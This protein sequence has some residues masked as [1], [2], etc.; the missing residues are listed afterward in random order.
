[1]RKLGLITAALLASTSVAGAWPWSGSVTV[2]A[3]DRDRQVNDYDRRTDEG[4]R[5]RYHA[6][7]G[8]YDDNRFVQIAAL[9][10][11]AKSRVDVG[12]QA[13]AFSRLRVQAVDGRPFVN[14][15]VVRFMNGG[16]ETLTVNRRL[17]NGE[18]FDA[19]LNTREPIAAIA[20]HGRADGHSQLVIYGQ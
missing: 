6:T 18:V 14:S 11:D 4:A 20:V 3:G 1:M 17:G 5:V 8:R 19:M 2:H 13:G 15:V 16:M 10:L 7:D 12:P 9:P